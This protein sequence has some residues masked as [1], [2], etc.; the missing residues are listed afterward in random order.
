MQQD[1]SDC[2][3]VRHSEIAELWEAKDPNAHA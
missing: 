2:K 1:A 3:V